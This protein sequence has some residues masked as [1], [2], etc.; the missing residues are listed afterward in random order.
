M[1]RGPLPFFHLTSA[2]DGV[3]GG[4]PARRTDEGP[5]ELLKP[6]GWF[7]I[8]AVLVR[9]NGLPNGCGNILMFSIKHRPK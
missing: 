1:S 7:G 9:G 3:P 6:G 4:R 8:Q 5:I 2:A